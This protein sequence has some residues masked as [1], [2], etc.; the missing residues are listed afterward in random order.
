[1]YKPLLMGALKYCL[2]MQLNYNDKNDK[3]KEN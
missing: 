1:M 3:I 2:D